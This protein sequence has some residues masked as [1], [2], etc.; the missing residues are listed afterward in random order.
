M[1]QAGILCLFSFS[2]GLGIGIVLGSSAMVYVV[3]KAT[4]LR[5]IR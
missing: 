3:Y 2:V 5:M 4:S 1:K